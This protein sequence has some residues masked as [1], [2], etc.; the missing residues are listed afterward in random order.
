MHHHNQTA[1]NGSVK[2]IYKKS[3][4]AVLMSAA[5]ISDVALP[6]STRGFT[7][8]GHSCGQ[9]LSTNCWPGSFGRHR[10]PTSACPGR[11]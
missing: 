7:M 3:P 1:D 10:P 6:V 11:K 4:L 2:M 8:R 5:Q 9:L